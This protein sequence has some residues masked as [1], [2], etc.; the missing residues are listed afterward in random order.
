MGEAELDLHPVAD[1]VQGDNRLYD[2][3]EK[4]VEE[5]EEKQDSERWDEYDHAGFTYSDLSVEPWTLSQ[6]EQSGI[7]TKTYSSG[8]SPNQYRVTDVEVARRALILASDE[9]PAGDEET[10]D[11][12]DVDVDDLFTDVVGY[13]E[14]K[15]WLRRTIEKDAPVHHLLYG[16]PG[17]GKT[18]LTDDILELP[19][20]HLVVGA[21]S[22][23]SAAGVVETLAQH[24]PEY[25]VVEEIEKMSKR[26]AEALLTLCGKG[27]VKQTKGDGRSEQRIE[28]DTNVIATANDYDKVTPD[29]LKSRLM[30][31]HFPAYTLN[32]FVDLCVE[33]LPRD[34]DVAEETAETVAHE[35]HARLDSTDPRDAVSVAQLVEDESEVQELVTALA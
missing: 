32:E 26:D 13:D 24:Q 4:A 1:T 3:L 22:Q 33:I 21:G 34:H 10:P 20:A 19:N 16:E 9:R 30:E 29:S 28:L 11:P 2:A 7:I 5:H 23:S 31:W 14:C 35:V 18:T 6:L 15:K 27:Y 25:L 8:N 17:S 12:E